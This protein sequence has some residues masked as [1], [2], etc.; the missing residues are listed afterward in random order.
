MEDFEKYNR[1]RLLLGAALLH[2]LRDDKFKSK[3]IAKMLDRYIAYPEDRAFLHKYLEIPAFWLPISLRWGFEKYWEKHWVHSRDRTLVQPIIDSVQLTINYEYYPQHWG[4]INPAPSN[5]PLTAPRVE[6][7]RVVDSDINQ[8]KA[9][10]RT[11]VND[12]GIKN[13]KNISSTANFPARLVKR[14]WSTKGA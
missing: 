1:F 4:R 14:V 7:R 9:N 6:Q 10:S 11:M 8:L 3:R 12:A 13:L 2:A 5:S